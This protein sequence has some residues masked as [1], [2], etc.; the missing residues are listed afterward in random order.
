MGYV[1]SPTDV[2]SYSRRD[3]DI[4][5]ESLTARWAELFDRLAL[6]V[7]TNAAIRRL[8]YKCYHYKTNIIH[9]LYKEYLRDVLDGRRS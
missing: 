1:E 8:V 6:D 4:H 7:T 9:S 5:A 2:E 3:A